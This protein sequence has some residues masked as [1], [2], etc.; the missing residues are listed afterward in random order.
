MHERAISVDQLGELA[1]WELAEHLDNPSKLAELP[2]FGLRWVCRVADVDWA[3]T[4]A[5]PTA[6]GT[7][8]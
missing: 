7:P 5:N 4:L 8:G 2:I 6:R 3:T 1:G